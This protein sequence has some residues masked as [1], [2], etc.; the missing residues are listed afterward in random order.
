MNNKNP[1]YALLVLLLLPGFADAA[2]VKGRIKYISNKANTIQ[3]DVKGKE[4]VVVQFD[5]ATV[6]KNTSGIDALNPPD[7]LEVEYEPG[8]AATKIKKIVFALPPGAEI[9]IKEMV[10]ILQGKRGK[11]TLGD[12]R[13]AKVYAT[14]HIPS[15]ISTFPNDKKAFLKSLPEDKAKLLVFYCGGPTCPFTGKAIKAA[16]EAGYTNIKGFQ[17]GIPAWKRSKLAIHV[18]PDWVTNNLDMHHIIID[19]RDTASSTSGHVKTAVSIPASKLVLMTKQFI[20]DQTNPQLPG[21]TD[22]RAPIV[23]YSDGHTDKNA[24]LAYKQLRD[25]GYAN[26]SILNGGFSKWAALAYPIETG[27]APTEIHYT[28]KLAK[29]AIAS[30]DFAALHAAPGATV[31]LDVRTDSETSELGMLKG[32]MHIPLDSLDAKLAT[33]PKDREIITY[34]EN[35]IRAEMAY[36]TLK[37]NGYKARYLDDVISVDSEGAYRP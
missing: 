29:G 7:L 4:P 18:K 35:G 25:W 30:K 14:G 20:K 10:A 13:P 32:A 12:A 5:S 34:C 22:K 3:L 17:A 15:A 11:Y 6:F 37:E 8:K 21:V 23:V 36:Q 26:A 27:A 16:M 28:K 19:A 24:L 2:T 1:M 33:L 9:D 31:F